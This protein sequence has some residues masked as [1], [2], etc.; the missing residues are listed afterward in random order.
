MNSYKICIAVIV[1]IILCGIGALAKAVIDMDF[2]YHSELRKKLPQRINELQSY[3]LN[4]VE[5]KD[6]YRSSGFSS[7]LTY[8]KFATVDAFAQFCLSKNVTTV[9]HYYG[10][11]MRALSEWDYFYFIEDVTVYRYVIE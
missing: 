3:G 11:M 4:I 5:V 9:M 7:T 1:I 2:A 8:V 10:N 6:F